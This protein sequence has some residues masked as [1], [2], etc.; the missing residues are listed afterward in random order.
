MMYRI[1]LFKDP[2]VDIQ[3]ICQAVKFRILCTEDIAKNSCLEYNLMVIKI[4]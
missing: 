2:F 1:L 4:V 3:L